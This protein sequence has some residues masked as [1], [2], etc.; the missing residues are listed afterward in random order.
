[1][2]RDILARIIKKAKSSP[3]NHRVVA[4]AL[5]KKGDFIGIKTNGKRISKSGGGLHAERL[6]MKQYSGI[7]SIILCRVN[8]SG[9]ILPIH[10]CNIC[11][12]IALK[13]GITIVS[14]HD[15]DKFGLVIEEKAVF[16]AEKQLRT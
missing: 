13:L 9:E 1:M 12:K 3:C 2:K 14:I 7:K 8:M 10:P 4:I 15:K 11:A 5:S 16:N 6:L